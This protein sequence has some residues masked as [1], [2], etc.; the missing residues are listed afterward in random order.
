MTRRSPDSGTR[1]NFAA[2]PEGCGSAGSVRPRGSH[3][4]TSR[5]ELSVLAVEN[6]RRERQAGRCEGPRSRPLP[7]SRAVA[8]DPR[9]AVQVEVGRSAESSRTTTGSSISSPRPRLAEFRGRIGRGRPVARNEFEERRRRGPAQAHDRHRRP[10]PAA[11]GR[12]RRSSGWFVRG[13]RRVRPATHMRFSM[14]CRRT[15][16]PSRR[17]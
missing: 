8:H 11:S 17:A 15:P 2:A 14:C 5:A 12:S 6:R 1:P 9:A 7:R 13:I 10:H 16:A 3:A 4:D